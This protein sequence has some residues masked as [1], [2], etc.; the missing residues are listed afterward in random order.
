MNWRRALLALALVG[1]CIW[2]LGLVQQVHSQ[3]GTGPGRHAP[4]DGLEACPETSTQKAATSL[5]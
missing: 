1:G 4:A 2:C 3:D 5:Q